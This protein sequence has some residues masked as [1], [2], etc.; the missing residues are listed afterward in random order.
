MK[1]RVPFAF[2]AKTRAVDKSFTRMVGELC[3]NARDQ[4]MNP[5]NTQ[6]Y[7]HGR[8]WVAH[9]AEEPQEATTMMEI[10]H[11]MAISTQQIVD[12][13]FRLFEKHLNELASGVHASF[14]RGL[15]QTIGDGA[16]RAGNIVSAKEK[17]NAEAFLEVLEKIEFGVN[18]DGQVSLPQL[19]VSPE[20]GQK[21]LADL[22]AQN[23][24]FKNRVE[25]V[26]AE[27]TE[28]ALQREAERKARFKK[29]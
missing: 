20:T 19:H 6:R 27:K 29:P 17:P 14:M 28:A 5:E 13:D 3:A 25:R 26:K 1:R 18:K 11:E 21:M 23:E 12:G 10:S 4:F 15:Y 2:R 9:Y 24:D 22:E 8:S 16:E 7:R